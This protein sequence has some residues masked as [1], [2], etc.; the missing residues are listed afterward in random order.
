MHLPEG[1]ID[2]HHHTEL[3]TTRFSGALDG[4]VARTGKTLSWLWLATVSVILISV[5]SRYVF[6]QGSILLEELSWH[7]YGIAWTMGLGYTLVTDDHVR[8]DVLHERF[9]LRAQAWIE[10]L[11]LLVLLLPFL[12][13]AIYYSIPYAHEAFVQGETSQAP[14]GLPYRFFLKSFIP[15]SMIF[16]ALAA[17]SRL[18]KC[19]ALLFGWPRPIKVNQ[20][21]AH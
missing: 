8:V 21:S 15:L 19:T 9:S 6:E 17:I 16:I 11:G 20:Q 3:P 12:A 18:F 5:I 14:S 7:I 4:F 13:I 1:E 2:I 10:I